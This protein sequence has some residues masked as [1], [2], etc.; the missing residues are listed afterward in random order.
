LQAA[1]FLGI[2][3]TIISYI[4]S[5]QLFALLSSDPGI[6][7]V[8]VPFVK[9]LYVGVIAVA[10]HNAFRGYWA[11]IEE[12]KVIMSISLFMDCLNIILNYMLIFGHLGAPRLGAVGAAIG[13]VTSL[14]TGLLINV[15][16]IQI[17][18]P[19]EG[20]LKAWPEWPLVWRI[21]KMS[22]PLGVQDI[23]SSASFLVLLWMIGKVGTAEVAAANILVRISL[24]TVLL[25]M[26]L[27]IASA[28]LVSKSLGEGNPA[29]A[30]QWGWDSGKLGVLGL[31]LLGLPLVLFPKLVL[32][33]FLADP[34]TISIA[35]L[36]MRMVGATVGMGSL[37]WIF[38]YTLYS[39]GDGNRVVAVSVGL[40]CFLLPLVWVVGPLLHHGLLQIWLVYMAYGALATI[41]ITALWA[42]GRWKKIEL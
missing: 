3:L 17:K 23:L 40:Q 37:I 26:S 29:G 2:P 21:Q 1:L 15:V 22:L 12:P 36:P 42:D 19:R 35:V 8:G 28:T 9:W 20:F 16:M 39:V 5:P 11:G 32:S 34:Y 14:Y 27:G 33:L 7:K 24:I 38:G 4:F 10:M 25:S 31:T 18:C 30:A 6:T 13:T 41:S